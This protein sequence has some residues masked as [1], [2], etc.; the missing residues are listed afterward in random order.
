MASPRSPPGTNGSP[1]MQSCAYMY[2]SL[3]CNACIPICRF[4]FRTAEAAARR[5]EQEEEQGRRQ[6]KAKLNSP[7]GR[8]H[9]RRGS[10]GLRSGTTHRRWLT[11]TKLYGKGRR[12]APT[13]KLNG[14]PPLATAKPNGQSARTRRRH[15]NR[16]PPAQGASGEAAFGCWPARGAGAVCTYSRARAS[17]RV[18]G[19]H[20]RRTRHG[21]WGSSSSDG[22]VYLG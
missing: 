10:G 20:E 7:V 9:R 3:L 12:A 18:H 21:V 8:R 22:Q 5:E 2:A 11:T 4:M 1:A 19:C 6:E 14:Q 17:T 15:P 16:K 13:L